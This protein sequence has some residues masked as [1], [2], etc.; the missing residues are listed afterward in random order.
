M[1]VPTVRKSESNTQGTED[2]GD[3]TLLHQLLGA[4]RRIHPAF[5]E[6]ISVD[7]LR[8]L[9]ANDIN[10]LD[11]SLSHPSFVT[12]IH[13]SSLRDVFAGR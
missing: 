12:I 10:K 8:G 1:G 6:Y 7:Q 11:P 3:S 13:H 2:G 5:G 9:F 4:R